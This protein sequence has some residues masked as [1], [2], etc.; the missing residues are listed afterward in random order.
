MDGVQDLV[1]ILLSP[2]RV[3]VEEDVLQDI[4]ARLLSAVGEQA[5]NCKND[6]E[7]EGYSSLNGPF[8]GDPYP[9]I[10]LDDVAED[11]VVLNKFTCYVFDRRYGWSEVIGDR[12][13]RRLSSTGATV[14][15]QN[16]CQKAEIN[17]ILDIFIRWFF[18][19]SVS[20]G[21]LKAFKYTLKTVCSMPVVRNRT[22][23]HIMDWLKHNTTH[24][25]EPSLAGPL[26]DLVILSITD[27]WS[28]V[29]VSCSSRL[30]P[31]ASALSSD[32]LEDLTSKL[33]EICKDEASPWQ[34]KEGTIL[35]L[36][37]IL[38][39]YTHIHSSHMLKFVLSDEYENVQMPDF[40]SRQIR[41]VVF[42]LLSHP[43]LTIRDSA[44]KL[45][46]IYI[47]CSD[48]KEALS[49][50]E[51]VMKIL[52]EGINIGIDNDDIYLPG[53]FPDAYRSE[54]FLNVCISVI[55]VLPISELLPNFVYHLSVYVMYL[56]HP[57]STVRQAASS[58]FKYLVL[59]GCH[60]VGLIKLVLH[61]LSEGWEPNLEILNTIEEKGGTS[62]F[63]KSSARPSVCDNSLKG[64]KLLCAWESREGRLFAYELVIK[65]LIKNHWL[66]T[67]GPAGAGLSNSARSWQL[68]SGEQSSFSREGSDLE[69]STSMSH[70]SEFVPMPT[71]PPVAGS[72][73]RETIIHASESEQ[74][75]AVRF[76][77]KD[78]TDNSKR[79]SKKD[80]SKSLTLDE[81]GIDDVTE[82][83]LVSRIVKHS[84]W[85]SQFDNTF[86]ALAQI[87]VLERAEFK[88]SGE[89]SRIEGS[90]IESSSRN[91]SEGVTGV[92]LE[93]MDVILKRLLFQTCEC[94]TDTQWELRRMGQ[95]STDMHLVQKV[96][97]L[98][99][100]LCKVISPTRHLPI[101]LVA[102]CARVSETIKFIV[103]CSPRSSEDLSLLSNEIPLCYSS[104][105]DDS[106]N[107]D[108]TAIGS[109]TSS[110]FP[111]CLTLNTSNNSGSF[112][113]GRLSA[114]SLH[115]GDGRS[116]TPTTS[117]KDG[118]SDW[119][120]W[121]E[122]EEEVESGLN[123][124]FADF[125]EKLK[126]MVN[127]GTSD[128]FMREVRKLGD[129]ERTLIPKLMDD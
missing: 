6:N 20:C 80:M 19:H 13:V 74:S 15:T 93:A 111:E 17:D 5:I 116:H 89:G 97:C 25:T 101:I 73:P 87:Q 72:S 77:S 127:T 66:Y 32:S 104:D 109:P 44:V 76:M 107:Q 112:H 28:A 98:Y 61:K 27:V 47:A 7:C 21:L 115:S 68:T 62:N 102:V 24:L 22:V 67:F 2:T 48:H 14:R 11:Q 38:H 92:E 49:T 95:Q 18:C 65:F 36:N 59:K 75:F 43:Q 16:K 108:I 125:L 129:K 85:P 33:I 50:L 124:V 83:P 45:L 57:A 46:S 100:E 99:L 103:E 122:E 9:S 119:D 88:E 40:I 26:I 52:E 79:S 96:G 69:F 10:R 121:D 106:S 113:S 37:S 90:R 94:L 114:L 41:E 23:I 53:Q 35:G 117:E 81:S 42:L 54:G 105:S 82:K 63:K 29:R 86:S 60:S 91:T 110:K 56:S 71:N 4:H 64:C 58:V 118:D 12:R 34:A 55:K 8:S 78:Y 1:H 51:D 39:L 70:S 120:S 123:T 84:S 31:I 30:G 126:L 3:D 128:A